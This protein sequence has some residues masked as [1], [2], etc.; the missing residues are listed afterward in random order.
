MSNWKDPFD[1]SLNHEV[2]NKPNLANVCDEIIVHLVRLQIFLLPKLDKEIFSLII[3]S[4]D[5]P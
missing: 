5:L 3:R 4:Q 2:A 1:C